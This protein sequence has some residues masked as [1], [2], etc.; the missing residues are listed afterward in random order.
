MAAIPRVS[1]CFY[2]SIDP[3]SVIS[4]VLVKIKYPTTEFYDI[5]GLTVAQI[6]SLVGGLTAASYHDI[7]VVCDKISSN[8]TVGLA[9][10]FISAAN[11]TTLDGKLIVV[12]PP[13]D[14][15]P[16]SAP[17]DYS[18][19]T[20]GGKL[21]ALNVFEALFSTKIAARLVTLFSKYN[22]GV[23]DTAS[24]LLAYYAIRAK[25]LTLA[26]TAYLQSL[27][28]MIDPESRLNQA[29]TVA[30]S[31]PQGLSEI[32]ALLEEG[33]IVKNFITITAVTLPE[34]TPVVV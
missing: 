13:Q 25:N 4:A 28:N 23:S 7:W 3:T 8:F 11:L 12:S 26:N 9:V 14:P 18:A 29:D 27:I 15:I 2:N 17:Q 24:A 10:A 31:Y 19:Q 16:D 33:T 20:S 6:N 5:N 30:T 1:A 34:G 22:L 32:D 21:R